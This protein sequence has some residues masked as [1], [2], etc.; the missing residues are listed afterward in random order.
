MREKERERAGRKESERKIEFVYLHVCVFACEFVCVF[1][2]MCVCVFV[3]L[4]CAY[5][6]II[7]L[8]ELAHKETGGGG[9]PIIRS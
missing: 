5:V 3:W 1:V 6:S 7:E 8:Q 2:C 4:C 9:Y